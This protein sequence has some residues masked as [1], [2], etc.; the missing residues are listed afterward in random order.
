LIICNTNT[1]SRIIFL[2]LVLLV[3]GCSST[4]TTRLWDAAALAG[5]PHPVVSILDKPKGKVIASVNTA[6]VRKLIFVKERVE[7]AAGELHTGLLIADDNDPNGFSFAYHGHPMIAINIGMINLLGQDE[8]AMA[9]LIG[10]ELAHLYLRHGE[11]RANR[12]GNRILASAYLSFA[13]GMIGI[14]AP[15]EVTDVATTSVSNA[16]SRDEER[17]ADEF[18]VEFMAHAGFDPWGAVRLQ[19]RLEAV[20]EKS[21]LP[22]LSTHPTSADRIENMKRLAMETKPDEPPYPDT[23]ILE[24]IETITLPQVQE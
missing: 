23:G 22:F 15:M 8:D 3:S 13:L 9:A 12:E 17:E 6:D 7:D 4:R 2:I 14:P 1:M 18:G 19:E 5:Y 11:R 16:F 24:K 21:V 10:H 20:S